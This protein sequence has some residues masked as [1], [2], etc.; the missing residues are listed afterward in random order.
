[1]PKTDLSQWK[2][3]APLPL[4][5]AG[6]AAGVVDGK[7]L[8]AGGT[9]WR[10]GRKFWCEQVDSFDPRAN[11]WE[12]AAPLPHPR[13][14][15][16]AVALADTLYVFGGG[17]DGTAES[18]AWSFQRGA[19]QP[20]PELNLPA[21]RRSSATVVLAGTIYLLGGLAGKGTE[22]DT[23][24]STVWSAKPRAGWESQA[25][26]P[27][28]VRFG[29]AVGG[30]DGRIIVAGGCTPENGAVRNLDD[31]LAYHPATNEWSVLGRLPVPS[32]GACGLVEGNRFLV[33]GGYT[34]KFESGILDLN[35]RTGETSLVGQL[36]TGLADTRFLGVGGRIVGVT[37]ENGIK[38]RFPGTIESGAAVN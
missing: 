35:P 7:L 16:A 11:R 25:P 9:Y 30:V 8:V 3:L 27:G 36:P 24:T 22:F 5:R 15:A 14:D 20:R 4:P 29:A 32:R 37:G 23:A 31:I 26:M 18:S 13:G 12:A 21:P 19:W 10:D 6:C 33:I 2:Q 17:T 38:M 28:P 1:M 34:D